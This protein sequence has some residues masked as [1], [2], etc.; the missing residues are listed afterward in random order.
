MP[1]LAF[2]THAAVKRLQDAGADDR[3]AEAVVATQG[4]AI[5]EHVATKTDVTALRT[6][7]AKVDTDRMVEIVTV[8][9]DFKTDIATLAGHIDTLDTRI[10]SLQRENATLRWMI[11]IGFTL[12]SIFL[13]LSTFLRAV[14]SS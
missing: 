11:G 6:E 14:L 2:D 1:F 3:L 12:L 13:A 9:A 5:T 8:R 7:I 4:A 10:Q